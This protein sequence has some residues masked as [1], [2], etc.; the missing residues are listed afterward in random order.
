MD[1]V[2]KEF[3]G[4]SRDVKECEKIVREVKEGKSKKGTE[5]R[6]QNSQFNFR[7]SKSQMSLRS[8]SFHSCSISHK[9][10]DI[11]QED[12]GESTSRDFKGFQGISRDFKGFQGRLGKL[13]KVG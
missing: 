12:V 2:F 5:A 9:L 10:G 4:I 13:R 3:Q 6:S 11:I 8:E 1:K 7:I